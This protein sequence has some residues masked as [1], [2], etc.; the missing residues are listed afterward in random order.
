MPKV[1]RGQSTL[2]MDAYARR[3]FNGD[4]ESKKQIALDVG[5]S[6]N[7]SN[8][9]ISH[10]ESKPSFHDAMARL[11]YE[12]NNLAMA[13]M[14][15]F[16][17]RGFEGFTNNEIIS[18]LNAISGAWAKFNVIPKEGGGN[19]ESTNKLRTV[20]MNRIENQT[21]IQSAKTEEI[22]TEEKTELDF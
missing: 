21:I 8:S 2:K 15:E 5:Y 4:G 9:V 13:A 20:V 11:A 7:V 17:A 19:K 12:S 22:K 3:V 18:A 14:E 10:I 16:K 1:K 6:S